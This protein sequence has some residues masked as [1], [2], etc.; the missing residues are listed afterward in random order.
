[1]SNLESPTTG[2]VVLG[3]LAAVL[4]APFVALN[5]REQDQ[6]DNLEA[7]AVTVTG[8]I[9]GKECQNH[10]QVHY[11]YVVNGK[12][13]RGHGGCPVDCGA[14]SIGDP[15]QVAYPQGKPSHSECKS[16]SELQDIINGNYFALFFVSFL[17]TIAIFRVT[18][19]DDLQT[20]SGR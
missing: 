2:R 20:R 8:Q 13:Y 5:Y 16:F 3:I 7:T 9:S 4:I 12:T 1:M 6:L 10:G 15:L 14:A 19:A 17:L 11:K 18:S